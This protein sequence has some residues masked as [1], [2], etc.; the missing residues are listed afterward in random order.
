MRLEEM[1][2]LVEMQ[3]EVMRLEEMEELVEMQ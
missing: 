2:E 3:Q 1:E